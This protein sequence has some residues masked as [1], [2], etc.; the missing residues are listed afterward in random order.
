VYLS[1]DEGVE[2]FGDVFKQV[3]TENQSYD[4]KE[5]E[6]PKDA[7]KN[8]AEVYEIW[9]K[10]ARK[11]YWLGKGYPELLDEKDDPLELPDFFPCPKPLY[12]TTTTG[13]LIPVPDYCEYQDQA[14][15]LDQLTQRISM[16]TQAL[17]VVGVFNG[18]YTSIHRLLNEG[19]DNDM[20]AV[21]A[22]AAFAEKGGMKGAMEFLPIENIIKVLQGLYE[23]RELTKQSIYELTGI[24]DIIRGATKASETLGAQQLKANYGGLRLKENQKAVAQFATDLLRM[25]AHIISKFFSDETIVEMSGI[26]FTPDAQYLPQ[27]LELLR[28]QLKT[29]R[30]SVESDSLAQLDDGKEKAERMEF[31]SATGAYLKEA[32]PIIQQSPQAGPLLGEMLLFGVRGFNVGASIESQFEQAIENMTNQPALPPEVQMQMQQMQEQLQQLQQENQ[33]LKS[34]AQEKMMEMQATQKRDE[35]EIMSEQRKQEYEAMNMDKKLQAETQAKAI[36]IQSD[37]EL[38]EY[39]A[40]IQQ[41]TELKKAQIQ[42]ETQ[43]KIAQIPAVV[44]AEKEKVDT[45]KGRNIEGKLNNLAKAQDEIKTTTL[46]PRRNRVVRGKDGKIMEVISEIIN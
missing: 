24:S 28:S 41:Q 30:I 20:I 39:K 17:K 22:W 14:E 18:E 45:E 40:R 33:Q 4:T 8:K 13:S 15:E 16:L 19:F 27:A 11:V 32:L 38:E 26:Q 34:G 31:L 5:K 21:D 46:L 12:S 6:T 44:K 37:R 42:A 43:L 10:A 25:K 9:D 23:S 3:P 2:R 7:L 35:M 29:F 1:E 36:E